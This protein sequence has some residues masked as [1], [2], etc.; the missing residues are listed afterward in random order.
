MEMKARWVVQVVGFL[1]TDPG[2][3]G[4][5]LQESVG[6]NQSLFV[7]RHLGMYFQG[8]LWELCFYWVMNEFGHNVSM[9]VN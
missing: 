7:L 5:T 8:W 9:Y 3:T 4:R 1:T 6:I 2:A